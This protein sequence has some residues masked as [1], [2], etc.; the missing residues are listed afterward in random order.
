MCL[1]KTLNVRAC[2]EPGQC[3]DKNVA[4]TIVLWKQATLHSRD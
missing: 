3:G 1:P 2:I 4:V